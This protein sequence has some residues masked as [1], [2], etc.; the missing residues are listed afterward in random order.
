MVTL[1]ICIAREGLIIVAIILRRTL[2]FVIALVLPISNPSLAGAQ[3]KKDS[4]QDREE[5][6]SYF[7]NSF[8]V[9]KYF[10]NID[11][12]KIHRAECAFFN[13]R[14]YL[15][16]GRLE[17]GTANSKPVD[18]LDSSCYQRDL[19]FAKSVLIWGDSHAQMLS[20]GIVNNI[21][22]TWQ[23]LQVATSG[24][25]PSPN[26][27]VP[28]VVSQCDQSN[29]FA[30]KTIEKAKPDV[31]VVAQAWDHSVKAMATITHR[32]SG[33]GVKKVLFLGPTPK[34]TADLPKIIA[35]HLWT[36][37]SKRT[38]IGI[39]LD[40]IKSNEKMLR[41]F[42]SSD[43]AQY[44]DVI[45]LFCDPGGC[46]TYTGDDF[47]KESITSFDYGHLTPSASE[48]LAKNVLIQRIVAQ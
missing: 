44:V 15:A 26:I 19:N 22:K 45:G 8:P 42:G 24:C 33:F 43:A 2:P 35:R 29:F 28:S 16:E 47:K 3:A 11:A 20:S 31:V 7:D 39:N 30:L 36:T 34:W 25:N 37:K 6:I 41:E 32:L 46:L 12:E 9:W 38:F 40:I 13:T 14:K 48:F 5:F 10:K 17:G 23:V 21:P 4:Q 1:T 27:E 18:K